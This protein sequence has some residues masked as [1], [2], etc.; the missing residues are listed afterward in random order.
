MPLPPAPTQRASLLA[1]KNIPR[2]EKTSTP[3]LTS[4]RPQA[5]AKKTNTKKSAAEQ[6]GY[7]TDNEPVAT[8]THISTDIPVAS[9][10]SRVALPATAK[11]PKPVKKHNGPTKLFVL[12]TNVLMHDPMCLFQFE[13]HDIYLPM[14]VLEE[15]D[16]HK[17]GMTEVARNA[18]QTSRSLDALA[19]APESDMQKGLPLSGTGHIEASGKLFFQTQIMDVSLPMSLPQGKADNQILG[20][21]QALGKLHAPREVVLVSKDIN[22]RVKARALGMAAEDYQNDKVLEDG[23][24][25]YSGALALPSDFWNRHGKAIESWQQGSYT[26]Y[27]F[28]GPLVPSLLINQFVRTRDRDQR[29]NSRIENTQRFWS[30]QKCS[31]GC[32]HSQSRAKLCHEHADR[33][34]N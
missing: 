17:K 4:A 13:E 3:P 18:R 29:Q 26:F 1:N 30:C 33:P 22:M 20:V 6:S 11:K 21:V 5:P 34:R 25:M 27:R 23:D 32:D 24:L 12:D 2:S 28:S 8:P 9:K 19:A 15:L 14:I 7:L 31:V 16:S 10:D